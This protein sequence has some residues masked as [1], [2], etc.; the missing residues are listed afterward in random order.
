MFGFKRLILYCT[1]TLLAKNE[2]D[3]EITLEPTPLVEIPFPISLFSGLMLEELDTEA[4]VTDSVDTSLLTVAKDPRLKKDL[5]APN[6]LI[7]Y[8][9]Y[10]LE[11]ASLSSVF[12]KKI[13]YRFVLLSLISGSVLVSYQ[14]STLGLTNESPTYCRTTNGFGL[15]FLVAKLF[16]SNSSSEYGSVILSPVFE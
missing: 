5:F 9:L 12:A 13:E 8:E 15:I 16:P 4:F 10:R 11:N 14:E 1:G 3:V 6:Q 2:S 7:L